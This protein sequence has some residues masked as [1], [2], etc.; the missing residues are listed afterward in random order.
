MCGGSLIAS[1]IAVTVAHCVQ[2][3]PLE[4]IK[5]LIGAVNLKSLSG[6]E[7]LRGVEKI[8][9]HPD[10]QIVP[11]T[12]GDIALIKIKGHVQFSETIRHICIFRIT[13]ST[14]DDAITFYNVAFGRSGDSSSQ[15]LKY[16][17]MTMIDRVSCS[18]KN[19]LFSRLSS[20]SSFCS[21]AQSRST[22]L[23]DTGGNSKV[24]SKVLRTIIY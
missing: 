6:T 13:T 19:L 22:N 18:D 9:V 5:L 16:G 14:P 15:L 21:E 3:I 24:L 4:N 1:Y 20:A 12:K 23:K 2:N 7:A 17:R 8:V 11:G 10:F